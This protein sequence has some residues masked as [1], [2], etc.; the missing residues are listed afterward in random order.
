MALVARP[1][2]ETVRYRP[3]WN[4][5]AIKLWSLLSF[6]MRFSRTSVGRLS[7]PPLQLQ[8]HPIHQSGEVRNVGGQQR[9]VVC[10]TVKVGQHASLFVCGGHGAEVHIR[11]GHGQQQRYF[12]AV[13][14]PQA[15]AG[16]GYLA[17]CPQ[18]A[19][20][21]M[22]RLPCTTVSPLL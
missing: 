10:R 1:E 15:V 2:P 4:S 16:A 12:L 14:N 22:P 13:L 11:G 18:P 20:K 3:Y 9:G 6:C 17:V 7:S 19:Q 8:S 21:R 5:R